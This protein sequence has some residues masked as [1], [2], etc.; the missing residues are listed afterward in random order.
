MRRKD[1]EMSREF[2]LDVIDN[3]VYGVLGLI[4]RE[5]KPYTLPL[6]LVRDGEIL[7]FHGA[8]EGKKADLIPLNETVSVSFVSYAEVPRLYD[9]ETIRGFIEDGAVRAL[10]SKVFTTEFASAHVEGSIERVDDIEEKKHALRLI[11]DKYTP[12]LTDLAPAV[13][14][15]SYGYTAVY[16]IRIKTLSAKRKRLTK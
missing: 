8:K 5:G 4:D 13:I 9:K 16:R 14:E 6:S 15:K 10:T 2:G 7:Y 12:D 1:R 3:A 11:C